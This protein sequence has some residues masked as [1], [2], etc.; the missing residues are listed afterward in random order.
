MIVINPFVRR[1]TRESSFSYYDGPMEN[2][3]PMIERAWHFRTP[4]YRDGVVLVQVP[5][6]GFY[7]TTCELQDGDRI[8]G[9]YMPRHPG[10]DPRLHL[11]VV[12]GKKLPAA[13]VDIVLYRNDVLAETGQHTTDLQDDH[14]EIVSINATTATEAEPIPVGALIANHLGLSGGTNTNMTDQEF[15]EQL[16]ISK[17]YWDGKMNCADERW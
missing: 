13:R 11:G 9:K 14:W 10:E 1:Q 17:A 3:I 6:E 15:V 7:S 2:L 16:R 12:N 8:V 4:G 5:A